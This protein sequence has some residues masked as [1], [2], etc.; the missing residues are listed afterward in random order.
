MDER[1]NERVVTDLTIPA[2]ILGLGSEVH[3]YNLS[4]DGCMVEATSVALQTD[5]ILSLTFLDQI[6]IQG[7]VIWRYGQYAGV[8]FLGEL[9]PAVVEHLGFKPSLVSVER[10][11]P[12]DRFDRPLP[13]LSAASAMIGVPLDQT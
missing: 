10:L 12:R 8:R 2:T 5:H 6:T 7:R 3:I 4:I 1:S 9:H 13:E 11:V